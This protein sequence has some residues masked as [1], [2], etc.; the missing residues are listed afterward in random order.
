MV[1]GALDLLPPERR[2]PGRAASAADC[3]RSVTGY[4]SGNLLISVICGS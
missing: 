4:I 3:A 2:R 1:D